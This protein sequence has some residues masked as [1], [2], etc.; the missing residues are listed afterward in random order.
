MK[1]LSISLY[2]IL[3]LLISSTVCAKSFGR[4]FTTPD[5]RVY[6]DKVR[7]NYKFSRTVF[8]ESKP[9]KPIIVKKPIVFNGVVRR[10]GGK[11]EIWI[12]GKKASNQKG[13][14]KAKNNNNNIL[15]KKNNRVGYI[16]VRP[17]QTVDSASGK[18]AEPYQSLS[19][20]NRAE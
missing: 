18:V 17:G 15:V 2:F 3:C 10:E 4:L 19:R 14:D 12:N 16:A 13:I 20:P 5:E 9:T 8:K 1:R 7:K 11:K 6:L